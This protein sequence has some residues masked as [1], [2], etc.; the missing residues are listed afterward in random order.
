[1]CTL[2]LSA[3]PNFWVSKSLSCTW[4][5]FCKQWT[6]EKANNVIWTPDPISGR[7]SDHYRIKSVQNAL[8]WGTLKGEISTCIHQLALNNAGFLFYL[9]STTGFVH[10]PSSSALLVFSDYIIFS[11]NHFDKSMRKLFSADRR[12][13]SS[14]K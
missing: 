1:M 3:D 9:G 7:E 10:H 6:L 14:R 8:S 12:E 5:Q 2:S 4:I 11:T 13:E